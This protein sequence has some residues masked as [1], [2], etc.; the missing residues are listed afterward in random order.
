MRSVVDAPML[1]MPSCKSHVCLCVLLMLDEYSLGKRFRSVCLA[2]YY[3]DYTAWS[4]AVCG[5]LGYFYF[6]RRRVRCAH[7]PALLRNDVKTASQPTRRAP[8]PELRFGPDFIAPGLL[9]VYLLCV[10]AAACT[11][12][13]KN[14]SGKS[15]EMRMLDRRVLA[16]VRKNT[17][18]YGNS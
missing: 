4:Y 16:I 10:N 13:A 12:A 15:S 17:L 6:E 3:Y 5:P 11:L 8:Q 1:D 7:F 9:Y 2:S 14:T 18:Y